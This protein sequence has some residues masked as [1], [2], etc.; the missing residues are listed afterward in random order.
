V[1]VGRK[2]DKERNRYRKEGSINIRE[3][4]KTRIKI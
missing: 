1:P 3:W 4:K 2:K